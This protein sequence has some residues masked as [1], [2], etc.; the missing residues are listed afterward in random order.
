MANFDLI[1]QT[2]STF[3][4]L[5]AQHFTMQDRPPGTSDLG[6]GIP[7]IS[8]LEDGYAAIRWYKAR[9]DLVFLSAARQ[10]WELGYQ[11][12]VSPETTSSGGTMTKKGYPESGSCQ[13]S[14][15]LPVEGATSR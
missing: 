3:H 15:N 9:G 13:Y 4:E 12:T 2:N 11:F 10:Q 7:V 14:N 6:S 8:A 5:A 1:N